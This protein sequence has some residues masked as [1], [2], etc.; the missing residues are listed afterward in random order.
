MKYLAALDPQGG[1]MGAARGHR[2]EDKDI[3][4]PTSTLYHVCVV[5]DKVKLPLLDGNIDIVYVLN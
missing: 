2:H 3:D 5:E 1:D 4:I